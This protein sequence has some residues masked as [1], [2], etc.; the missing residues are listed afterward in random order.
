MLD[1]LSIF[2]LI[3][4]FLVGYQ[5]PR[6]AGWGVILIAPILGPA[7]F[8]FV[9]SMLLPLTTYRVAFAITL[10]VIL[11][12]HDRHGIPLSS[13]LLK[14]TFVKIVVVFSL[15]VILISLE[16]RL[17]NIIFTYIPTLILAFALCYILIRD[18]KDL[19]RLVKIF[20]WQAALISV[21]IMFEYF[22]DFDINILLR[23]TIPGYDFSTLQSKHLLSIEKIEGLTRS[24]I[25]RAMGIDGN[26][27]STAYRLAFLFPLALFYVVS[28]KL[29]LKPW[30]SLPL[31]SV[32]IG[33]YL[34]QTRAAFVG[35]FVSLLALVIGIALLKRVRIIRK[36]RIL[37]LLAM[38]LIVPSF[39]VVLINP[40]IGK[41]AYTLLEKSLYPFSRNELSIQPKLARIPVAID[42]FMAKPFS[43]YGSPQYAYF[44]VMSCRDL[45]SPVIYLLAGG[46]SLCLIYLV[47]IFYMPYSVFRL[48]RRGGLNP[49]QRV[50]LTYAVAAFVG[51]VVVV[52]SNW[53]ETHFMI[54]YMFY[55]SIYKVYLY[56]GR[57]ARI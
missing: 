35:V 6:K 48:S 54:M 28:D 46:I 15:F 21:F 22:T 25:V 34:L 57:P 16:D 4:S 36:L 38:L 45:P 33:L 18:E 32:V 49:D 3:S 52:F 19:K 47:M 7:T 39:L 1:L 13:I 24:G 29:L 23:K 44:G 56:R 30:R 12:N 10:G 17:K 31:L 11:R 41:S 51:G 37:V 2:G 26:A 20:V 14:S 53:Q 8:T 43:G 9:P 42:Y 55:I 50:F 27:V 40:S 5:F